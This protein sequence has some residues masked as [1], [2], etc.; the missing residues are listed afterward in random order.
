MSDPLH[1]RAAALRLHALAAAGLLDARALARGLEL[2]GRHPDA[3]AWYRFARVHLILLGAALASVGAVFFVAA[4][5]DALPAAARIAVAALAVAASTVA[6]G[7]IGLERLSGRAAAL[8]GGLLFG[9]L[10]ALVG[11]IYQT[12]ADAWELFAAWSAVLL[13]FAAAT[14]FAGAWITAMVL[15]VVTAYLWIFQR[16]GDELF[17]APELVYSLGVSAALTAIVVLARGGAALR[18]VAAALGGL[19]AFLHGLGGIFIEIGSAASMV[20]LAWSIGQPLVVRGALGARRGG[21]RWAAVHLLGLLA[22]FEG[23][24]IFVDAEAKEGGLLALG[25]LLIGQ[26]YLVSK[27]LLARA[28]EEGPP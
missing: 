23:R 14:R 16:V 6:G 22:F 5:W 11:Q 10:M 27:L 2:V 7:W 3:E 19:I 12:G 18:G 1:A 9:P 26:G 20:A 28:A 15:S 21:D 24:V 8:A 13:A 17:E 25:L 4:N